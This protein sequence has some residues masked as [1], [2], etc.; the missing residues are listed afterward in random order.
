MNNACIIGYGVV[1][2]A[3]ALAF[4][5]T[6]HFDINGDATI[7][8]ND[9]ANC[10]YVFICLPTPTVNGDCDTRSI[11]EIIR[12]VEGIRANPLYIIRSTVIP[13]T[14]N[15]IMEE[16]NMDRVISN[17]EFLTEAT[18]ESD[19]KRPDMVII[20]GSNPNYIQEVRGIYESRFKYLEPKITD[21]VTAE[22]L[23][24]VFNNFFSLKV[25]F[26]EEMADVC[27]N[28]GA[29]Y[30]FIRDRLLTHPWGSGHHFFTD[31]SGYRG[32]GGKCLKKDLESFANYSKSSLLQ[33]VKEIND[34]YGNNQ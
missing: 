2:K 19:A 8:L 30:S 12:Q 17:P 11:R 15:A 4:G 18:W 25:I 5:I 26:A 27:K 29:N 21:N 33:K 24:Y 3:T 10:R 14:A 34:S 31:Y 7:T 32:V 23:K 1:G 6:K 13:G 9:A 22:T 28:N 20:G 16:L